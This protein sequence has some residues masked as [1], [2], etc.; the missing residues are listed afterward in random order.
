MLIVPLI[1]IATDR[2]LIPILPINIV[3]I[4]I[5][6]LP[7]DNDC[8][9]PVLK[10]TVPNADIASNIASFRVHFSNISSPIVEIV[11]MAIAIIAIDRALFIN[12]GG[13]LL[14]NIVTPLLPLRELN[15]PAVTA[16]KVVVFI[17]PPVPPGDAPIN[18]KKARKKMVATFKLAVLIVLKPAVLAVI[19]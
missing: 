18:I 12:L 19:D 3:S 4:N 7:I 13:S 5:I 16:T 11:I 17:P 9:I 6:L 15:P 14:L 2:V 10:P 8:V 1:A